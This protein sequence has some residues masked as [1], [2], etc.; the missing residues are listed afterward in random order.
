ML[1]A[2]L[3]L[4]CYIL[5]LYYYTMIYRLFRYSGSKMMM[6]PLSMSGCFYSKRRTSFDNSYLLLQSHLCWIHPDPKVHSRG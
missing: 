2:W 1:A 3:M 4:P 5:Q 6:T